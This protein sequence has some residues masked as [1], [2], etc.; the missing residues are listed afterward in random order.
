MKIKSKYSWM[1]LSIVW[2]FGCSITAASTMAQTVRIAGS[3]N[4]N[5]DYIM[6]VNALMD[7]E[8][9]NEVTLSKEGNFRWEERIDAPKWIEVSFIPQNR[10]QQLGA[11]FPLYIEPGDKLDLKLSYSK[12]TYLQLLPQSKVGDNAALIEYSSFSNRMLRN[13]FMQRDSPEGYKNAT[14]AYIKE[15]EK[16][17]QQYKI[18]QKEIADYLK[19]W[20]Y[21]NYLGTI[22]NRSNMDITPELL[23]EIP[24]VM[25]NEM[26]L[27]FY[28]GPSNVNNFIS[29][30]LPTE[31]DAIK[32][33]EAKVKKLTELFD[34]ESLILAVVEGDL[35][36]YV[37]SYKI[38]DMDR[39]AADVKRM[40]TLVNAIGS[41]RLQRSVLQDFKNLHHTSIGSMVPS[42]KFKDLQG[43]EVSLD[44]FKGNYIYIDLWASWCVPCIKEIP[45][46]HAVEEQYKDKNIVFVSISLDNNKSAWRNKVNELELEGLQWEL[47][48]SDY[49]KLMNV[50][51]IPHFILYGP[52]GKLLQYKAPRPSSPDLKTIFD[53]I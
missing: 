52:D 43:N 29:R 3:I 41:E 34:N 40:E 1:A 46:L 51:G 35:R 4:L 11:S 7:R 39:F 30:Q 17:T 31:P 45:Y 14:E 18:K 25:D 15:A 44:Q 19:L 53:K 33:L 27:S 10:N 24:A 22:S 23:K 8:E 32:Q 21:N 2:L 12:E 13:I 49:D 47:G 37:T 42:V 16:L 38:V 6:V 28:N 5:E 36:R 9:M 50:S 26:T 20:S 48:D